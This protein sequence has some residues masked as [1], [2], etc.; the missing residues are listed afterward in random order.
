MIAHTRLTV[1]DYTR[2]K[3]F[4]TNVL[5]TLGYQ[6]NME[7]GTSAGFNDGKNTDF[8][9]SAQKSVVPTHLAFQARDRQQVEAF[10]RAAVTAGAKD[11]G[12]PGYRDYSPDTS[13][14]SSST[15]MATTSR[16]FG[17]TPLGRPS[18]GQVASGVCLLSST[19]IH[20]READLQ[21][22][23]SISAGMQAPNYP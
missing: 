22:D 8:W 23:Q 2:S 19:H 13:R 11:N 15:P 5:A 17:T 16:R 21:H 1:S 20:E 14:L 12:Y 7:H 18:D 6:Q 3:A 4:Y 9:I 10:H